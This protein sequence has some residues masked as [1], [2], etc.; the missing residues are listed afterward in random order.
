MQG[1]GGTH[2]ACLSCLMQVWKEKEKRTLNYTLK[3]K[4]DPGCDIDRAELSGLWLSVFFFLIVKWCI[5]A[6]LVS[7]ACSNHQRCGCQ[8]NL[9][10]VPSM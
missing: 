3:D 6:R 2:V 8:K 5:E 7:N 1:K 10:A 4:P 9:S